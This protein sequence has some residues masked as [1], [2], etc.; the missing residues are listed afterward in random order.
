MSL[1]IVTTLLLFPLSVAADTALM[2]DGRR[3][4]VKSV[5][6]D[7]QGEL[8]I[9]TQEIKS[10]EVIQWV[11]NSP[12]S[13]GPAHAIR[14]LDGQL[15]LGSLRRMTADAIV[16]HTEPWGQ[17]MAFAKKTIAELVFLRRDAKA[18]AGKH[19]PKGEMGLLYRPGGEPVPCRLDKVSALQVS[20][21]SRMG[22]F[23]LTTE[24]LSRYMMQPY[25]TPLAPVDASWEVGLTDGSRLH[26]E[27][28]KLG[29]KWQL[30]V[31]GKPKLTLPLSA[32][33]YVRRLR[34]N[35]WIAMWKSG[36]APY[37]GLG[38]EDAFPWA[39]A[40]R[41]NVGE[42]FP[43]AGVSAGKLR[44]QCQ[45]ERGKNSTLVLLSGTK[46]RKRFALTTEVQ[47]I[48][49]NV[50]AG[51]QLSLR[52]ESDDPNARAYVGDLFIRRKEA[53]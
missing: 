26:G 29:N 36:K 23:N 14:L 18:R 31:S 22:A 44:L 48:G 11:T 52:I 50:S 17:E 13:V 43:I 30:R 15:F 32:I 3:V 20:V 16:L 25:S 28:N 49:L 21:S 45:Q 33:R 47:S 51:E 42:T 37:D 4:E 19:S 10:G 27:L 53:R 7:K 2:A 38:G 46:E 5:S 41:L 40:L 24:S 35:P 8:K 39:Q 9:D 12:A 1:A 34:G 6:L